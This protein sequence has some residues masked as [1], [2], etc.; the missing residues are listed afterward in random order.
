MAPVRTS[1]AMEQITAQLKDFLQYIALQFIKEPKLAELRI[2][3]S[4]DKK[5]NFRL[6]LCQPDVAVLI[7]RQGYTA[8]TIRSM[9]K[10]AAE[11]EGVIAN[12]RIHSHEEEQDYIASQEA[13]NA[14]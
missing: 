3:H 11:R 2:G 9:L 1:T 10:A 12:L 13:K 5:I 7:G 4:G 6:I 8:S 14:D